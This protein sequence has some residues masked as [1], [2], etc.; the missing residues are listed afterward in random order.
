M[1]EGNTVLGGGVDSCRC[2]FVQSQ[3]PE[4]TMFSSMRGVPSPRQAEAAP[5]FLVRTERG[6]D[7]HYRRKG[8][9]KTQNR[10]TIVDA[11]TRGAKKRG[12]TQSKARQSRAKPKKNQNI[13]NNDP[14]PP[15]VPYDSSFFFLR[16]ALRRP[17]SAP[18]PLFLLRLTHYCPC[19]VP[20]F[21]IRCCSCPSCCSSRPTPS[22][23]LSFS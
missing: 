23:F 7:M 20:L 15:C 13:N 12:R 11:R 16:G 21:S 14:P 17:R 5:P 6:K 19:I 8:S 9:R 22:S 10:H 18:R 1:R 4:L 2:R 3:N